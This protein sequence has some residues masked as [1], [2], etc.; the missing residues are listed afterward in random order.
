MRGASRV[1]GNDLP[2]ELLETPK[3]YSPYGTKVDKKNRMTHG[4]SL[5]VMINGQSAAKL[6]KKVQRLSM[7]GVGRK[8]LALEAAGILR[9]KI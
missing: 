7:I 6:L 5:N 9:V 8:R 3:A 4:E 1:T 2:V